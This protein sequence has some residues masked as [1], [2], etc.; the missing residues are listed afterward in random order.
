MCVGW[1]VSHLT[2]LLNLLFSSHVGS[3]FW[4]QELIQF[5]CG[6]S[7]LF[8]ERS[9]SITMSQRSRAGSP[10]I[11]NPASIEMT[12]DSVEL[13]E[14]EVCFL[15]I[16]LTGTN[17]WLPKIHRIPPVVDRVPQDFQQSL[18]LGTNPVCNA[19]QC[20]PN[21]NIVDSQPCDEKRKS[22]LLILCRMP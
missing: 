20:F 21:D 3:W 15:R 8:V 17:V 1:Y 10:S 5:P 9:T 19:V 13:C 18:S 22:I 12:S 14:N 6:L 7:L 16:Q 2:Q 11:R 4:N